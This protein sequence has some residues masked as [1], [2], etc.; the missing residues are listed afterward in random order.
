MKQT[1]TA[2]TRRRAGRDV[3]R[4]WLVHQSGASL[5]APSTLPVGDDV[6]YSYDEKIYFCPCTCNM[7]NGVT[8]DFKMW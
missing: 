7:Y 6:G 3:R 1:E 2:L 4:G 8:R 5:L